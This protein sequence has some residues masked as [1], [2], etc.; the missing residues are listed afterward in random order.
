MADPLLGGASTSADTGL[1]GIDASMMP[2]P[3]MD[4]ETRR[5]LFMQ[6]GLPAIGIQ[7][8]TALMM[9]NQ[10]GLTPDQRTHYRSQAFAAPMAGMAA[11]AD[12]EKTWQERQQSTI[13]NAMLMAQ[14]RRQGRTEAREDQ[15]SRYLMG[16]AQPAAGAPAGP[17][18]MTAGTLPAMPENEV[19]LAARILHGE[20]ANQ[21]PEGL[22]AAAHVMANRS[23]LTGTSIGGVV[24]APG[25]FQPWGDQATRQRL[26][27]MNPEQ[28]A[29][30]RQVLQGV[31]SGQIPD[32][33]GGA[34][35]FLNPEMTRQQNG[36]RLPAWAPPDQGQ[37]IGAHVFYS[38]P[39]DFRSVAARP[40]AAPA[41]A[42]PGAPGEPQRL[43]PEDILANMTPQQRALI[44]LHPTQGLQAVMAAQANQAGQRRYARM[45]EQELAG[46]GLPAATARAVAGLSTR[47]EQDNAVR[48]FATREQPR[49]TEQED[50]LRTQFLAQPPVQR[51]AQSLPLYEAVTSTTD[52][53]R[54]ALRTNGRDQLAELDAVIGIANLFDPGSVVREGEVANVIRTQGLPGWLQQQLGHVTGGQRMTTQM[55]DQIERAAEG[56]MQAYRQ[57][58]GP[59]QQMFQGVAERRGLNIQNVLPDFGD[60]V[61]ARRQ[62]QREA[63]VNPPGAP[64]AQTP[65]A[66]APAPP[67]GATPAEIGN[68][69]R[70]MTTDP[71]TR[72]A[73]AVAAGIPPQMVE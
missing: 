41:A 28:Y 63:G 35:H 53:A 15:I 69:I 70:A 46:L 60:P 25:Q 1:L 29:Q 3:M 24:T 42:P 19:D 9:A 67:A 26:L 49:P 61:E 40:G 31:L 51:Y 45:G 38:R 65:P 5:R 54:A 71:A 43:P 73:L 62:R 36:G 68:R 16:G 22:A 17:P 20:A 48:T 72:R 23:R 13:R 55:L 7:L 64:G 57:S 4:D 8:G 30:A 44:A 56:R 14:L 59:Y 32:P 33:T 37:R 2:S 47:E 39:Q 66:G 58:L 18:Q 10:R 6:Q 21:G 11:M 34:T 50:T 52:R 27:A 12:A